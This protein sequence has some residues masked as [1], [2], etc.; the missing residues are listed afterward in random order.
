MAF[1]NSI[2]HN[3]MLENSLNVAKINVNPG[4]KQP[5]MCLTFFGLNNISQSMVFSSDH[6][7]YPNEPKGM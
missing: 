2:N 6:S 7:Q 3:A 5:Q 1:N 4:G